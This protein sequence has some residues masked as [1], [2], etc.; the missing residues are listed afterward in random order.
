MVH[1]VNLAMPD[2]PPN[3]DSAPVTTY[4]TLAWLTAPQLLVTD[5]D[6]PAAYTAVHISA[7]LLLVAPASTLFVHV[8]AGAA[9]YYCIVW[10]MH[11]YCWLCSIPIMLLQVLRLMNVSWLMCL[12]WYLY[13]LY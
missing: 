8:S 13:L 4:T 7:L 10:C 12:I 3:T 2:A 11:W 6:P 9:C 5:I 1:F